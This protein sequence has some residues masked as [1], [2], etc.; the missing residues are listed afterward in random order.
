MMRLT[1]VLTL[2]LLAGCASRESGDATAAPEIDGEAALTH[3]KAM[4]AIGPR[5]AGSEGA[6]KTV[7]YLLRKARAFGYEPEVDQWRED[8]A[9]GNKTFRNVVATLPGRSR[10]FIIVGSHYD[11]KKLPG[12]PDFVGANDSASST[13]V[14]LEMMR[15]LRQTGWSGPELRFA[16]FDGEE[17]V[18]DYGPTDGLHGSKR[19]ARK[20]VAAGEVKDCRAMLLL[21]MVG[22]ADLKLTIP[23]NCSARLKKLLAEVAEKRGLTRYVGTYGRG[24]ILDDHVPFMDRGIPAINLIDFRYGPG[25]SY[26]HTNQDTLARIAADSLQVSGNLALGLLYELDK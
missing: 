21:D 25:N 8:T 13:G 9:D 12:V 20:L 16:F 10:G 17:A 6:K 24:A 15:V 23:R 4:V 22:D 14:L 5:H 11:T 18:H 2:L 7:A 26:W 1:T 3:A 19:M